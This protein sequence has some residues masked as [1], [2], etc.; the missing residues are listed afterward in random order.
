MRGSW[1]LGEHQRTICLSY[2]RLRKCGKKTLIS[3]FVTTKNSQK[4]WLFSF[5]LCI[6]RKKNEN[7]K[8]TSY[9]SCVCVCVCAQGTL[10]NIF[11]F[12]VW[13]IGESQ[14]ELREYPYGVC[15]CMCVHNKWNWE[16]PHTEG[17]HQTFQG[18]SCQSYSLS[19][20]FLMAAPLLTLSVNIVKMTK[21]Q[22]RNSRKM[23]YAHQ[24]N[25]YMRPTCPR[26]FFFC[27]FS[28]SKS[29]LYLCETLQLMIIC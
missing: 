13:G 10:G 3:F 29:L 7:T 26:Y 4:V 28:L 9:V 24:N 18:L 11:I 8:L 19:L 20:S 2:L 5:A 17:W 14:G 1:Y 6:W 27:Q 15:V 25:L 12:H 16:T 21:W 22:L 23:E